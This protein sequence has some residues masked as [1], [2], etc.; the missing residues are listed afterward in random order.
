MSPSKG[1]PC[2]PGTGRWTS[3]SAA[4]RVAAALSISAVTHYA[5]DRREPLKRLAQATGKGNFWDPAPPL[6]GAY[7]LD[8]ALNVTPLLG[9][10]TAAC[11]KSPS[12]TPAANSTGATVSAA[13]RAKAALASSGQSASNPPRRPPP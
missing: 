13:Y 3:V 6:G 12:P 10:C 4:A 11:T 1:S 7:A 9:R 2:W 5:A 8:Q